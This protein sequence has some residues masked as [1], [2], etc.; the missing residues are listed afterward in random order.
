[1]AMYCPKCSTSYEQRLQC[2]A[3]G[4]RLIMLDSGGRRGLFARGWQHTPVGR[5][6]VGLLLAQGLFYGLRHFLT[7]ILLLAVGHERLPEVLASLPGLITVQVLQVA[8]LLIGGMLAGAAQRSGLVLGLFLGV[9]NGVV[10]VIAQQWPATAT[11]T[12][13][14]TYGQPVIQGA[15]GAVGGWLG[16]T[17]WR[18]LAV[19]LGP[20]SAQV[21]RVAV[22]RPMGSPFAGR[23][24]W[25]RILI[26]TAF[27]VAGCLS[28]TYL[29]ERVAMVSNDALATDSYWQERVVTWE[30]KALAM[31]LGGALAG[32]CT[33]NGFKQGVLVGILS[34]VALNGAVAMRAP[35]L[36]FIGLMMVSSLSLAL[37]G[38]WFG[39][40]LFPPVSPFKRLR[41]MGPASLS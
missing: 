23:I 21:K 25:F 11:Q 27:A 8:A 36:Q 19:L 39:G 33:T 3:C 17:I 5:V 34:G 7:G 30:I 13:I 12:F 15:V 29:L 16:C 32:A 6:F 10:A 40:Q 38:G 35:T 4:E 41:G 18:P 31:L 24:H 22:S 37:V 28:A 26:G 14:P 2:P 20:D 9:L 1:M